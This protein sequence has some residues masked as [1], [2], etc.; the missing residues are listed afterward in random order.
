AMHEDER[1]LNVLPPSQ[2]PRA[3]GHMQAIIDMVEVLIDKGFAYA[4]D[5]GDV[6]YR[7]DKFENYGALT[8]RKLEDMRAGARIEIG[9]SKENP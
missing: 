8:N 6:Y 7:V 4:A 3:T 5:N 9:D 2:E 1:A